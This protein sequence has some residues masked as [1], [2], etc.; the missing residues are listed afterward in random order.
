[1]FCLP[2][3]AL[4]PQSTAVE[5]G[6]DGVAHEGQDVESFRSS[7]YLASRRCRRPNHGI[8]RA[9]SF[10]SLCAVVRMT[11]WVD[12]N[13][14]SSLLVDDR[15]EKD[16]RLDH[17]VVHGIGAVL[18]Q[19][20]TVVDTF[21]IAILCCSAVQHFT[22]LLATSPIHRVIYGSEAGPM[23]LPDVAKVANLS[24]CPAARWSR[25][26]FAHAPTATCTPPDGHR[27]LQA[28]PA[29]RR[30]LV[31]LALNT[32]LPEEYKANPQAVVDAQQDVLAAQ[33]KTALG[34]GHGPVYAVTKRREARLGRSLCT[35]DTRAGS[36]PRQNTVHSRS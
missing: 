1:M 31:D 7:N 32:K 26:A 21:T 18:P 2:T 10:V 19:S 24:V 17:K 30:W 4:T 9:Y 28:S 29:A 16:F 12:Q 15:L 36:S 3:L 25:P 5:H 27:V 22:F 20:V 14:K 11:L 13:S 6:G 23:G 8:H 34:T 35:F 33:E